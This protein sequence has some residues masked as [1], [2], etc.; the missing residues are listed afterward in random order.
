M[1]LTPTHYENYLGADAF[2]IVRIKRALHRAAG[3]PLF[4]Y[5]SPQSHFRVNRSG[6]QELD[7]HSA[8]PAGGEVG[9]PFHVHTLVTA[10][11]GKRSPGGMTIDQGTRNTA[12]EISRIRAMMG[13][14]LPSANTL[15]PFKVTLN[16]KPV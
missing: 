13:L 10:L 4:D 9:L 1:V 12:I 8:G 7:V 14:R 11:Q 15:V 6:L 5:F 3:T 2:L 16:L